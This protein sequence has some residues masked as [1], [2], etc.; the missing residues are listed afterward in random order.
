MQKSSLFL[1]PNIAHSLLLLK[2][3]LSNLTDAYI[4]GSPHGG[5]PVR[6]VCNMENPDSLR[7]FL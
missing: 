7:V 4:R 3:Q 2:T 1:R 5:N 6:V